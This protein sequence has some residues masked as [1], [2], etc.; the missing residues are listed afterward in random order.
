M[1][2]NGNKNKR[3]MLLLVSYSNITVMI[4]GENK[5]FYQRYILNVDPAG[6][7]PIL[8]LPYPNPGGIVSFLFSP[9]HILY[10]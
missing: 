2:R 5:R 6:I 8:R 3:R 4:R 1:A 7:G 10:R 9:I